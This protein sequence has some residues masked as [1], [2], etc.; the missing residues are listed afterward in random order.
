[1]YVLQHLPFPINLKLYINI[2]VIIEDS[3]NFTER[4]FVR[5]FELDNLHSTIEQYDY[6]IIIDIVERNNVIKS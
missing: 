2:I 3:L 1:M 6:V 4:L 5:Q